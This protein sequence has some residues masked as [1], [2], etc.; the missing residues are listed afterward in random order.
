MNVV[1]YLLAFVVLVL[2]IIWYLRSSVKDNEERKK[3]D[4]A[5]NNVEIQE[6]TLTDQKE[7]AGKRNTNKSD[8]SK[9]LI[10]NDTLI[11]DG[12]SGTGP[13]KPPEKP[14]LVPATVE[15]SS[16]A[17]YIG[18]HPTNI[19]AQAGPVVFPYVAM[20][21]PKCVI[22]FPRKGRAGRR[23]VKEL[24]FFAELERHFVSGCKLYGDRILLISSGNNYYE[25]DISLIDEENGL[26]LFVD[27]EVDEPYEGSNDILNRSVSHYQGADVNRNSAFTRRGWVVIRF[28]EIQVHEQLLSCCRF[29]SDVITSINPNF[30]IPAGL[31]QEAIP[32]TVPQWSQ[33]QARIWSLARYREEYLGIEQFGKNSDPARLNDLAETNAEKAAE[34]EVKEEVKVPPPPPDSPEP[35][36]HKPELR[37]DQAVKAGQYASFTLDGIP[38]IVKPNEIK[39]DVLSGYCYVQNAIR[40]FPIIK[41]ENLSITS[42][43]F[44]AHL[45]AKDTTLAHVKTLIHLTI[46]HQKLMRMRYTRS[47]F[48]AFDVDE[49]GKVSITSPESLKSLRTISKVMKPSI[50]FPPGQMLTYKL[51]DEDYFA[52]YCHNS[53]VVKAFR[54]DRVNEL[55]MLNV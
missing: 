24:A 28:A 9:Y 25:P 32:R 1:A 44:T 34:E 51:N 10:K 6:Q 53:L 22:K 15:Q 41:I 7:G 26:N 54:Y 3:R 27:I 43:V 20:P 11:Q 5:I 40:S 36:V 50:A 18:Y 37:L 45:V 38:T 13:V 8:A 4:S 48:G 12:S 21:E 2:L 19:F 30:Q 46:T 55:A 39:D 47:G 31:R 14:V 42:I 35:S 52:A 16:Q 23:G 49:D 29:V 17:K 33:E